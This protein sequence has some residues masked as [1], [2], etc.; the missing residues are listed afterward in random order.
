MHR[1]RTC[2]RHYGLYI[3]YLQARKQWNNGDSESAERSTKS[4][5]RWRLAGLLVAFIGV[6][7]VVVSSS[8]RQIIMITQV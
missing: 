2:K 5:K 8:L 4:A 6:M 1:P 3:I 7:V